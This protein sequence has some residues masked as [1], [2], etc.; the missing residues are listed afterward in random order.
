[1]VKIVFHKEWPIFCE[2][3]SFGSFAIIVMALLT[4]DT[5]FT[6]KTWQFLQT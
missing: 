3:V 1:M 5:I 6:P 2:K 4:V